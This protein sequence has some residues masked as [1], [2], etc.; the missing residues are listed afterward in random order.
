MSPVWVIF[1]GLVPANRAS[2]PFGGKEIAPLETKPQPK[3]EK[4]VR[5]YTATPEIFTPEPHLELSKSSQCRIPS[6]AALLNPSSD[7]S[8]FN[9]E[10]AWLYFSFW[11]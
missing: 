1:T 4:A 2:S 11:E 9:N 10:S 3:P 8:I 6:M 5:F 7:L